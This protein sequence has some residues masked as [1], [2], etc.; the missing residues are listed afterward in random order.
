MSMREKRSRPPIEAALDVDR[1]APMPSCG[2]AHRDPCTTP[3]VGGRIGLLAAGEVDAWRSRAGH[4]GESYIFDMSAAWSAQECLQLVSRESPSPWLYRHHELVLEAARA[5]RAALEP[6]VPGVDWSLV[7]AGAA[8]HDIG[9]A[10][11]PAEMRGPG[12]AHEARGRLLLL[13]HGAPAALAEMC[14][15]HG[16]WQAEGRTAEELLVAL[17]DC[18]WKGVRK[19]DLEH[20]T[21]LALER[22]A[23]VAPWAL[24]QAVEAAC[25]SVSSGGLDRLRRSDVPK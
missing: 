6:L 16:S 9:K 17:A 20:R 7:E 2:S 19:L 10:A 12:G 15:A 14:V 22:R 4:C 21:A 13:G 24:D 25:E 8:V 1:R 23:G 11:V 18:T 3:S 5:L